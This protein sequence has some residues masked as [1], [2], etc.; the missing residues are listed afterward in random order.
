MHFLQSFTL[1][2]PSAGEHPAE[3]ASA[4]GCGKA[5]VYSPTTSE[6]LLFYQFLP[7]KLA[8]GW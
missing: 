1:I 6:R 2:R 5:P 3:C 8:Y 7:I 4:K